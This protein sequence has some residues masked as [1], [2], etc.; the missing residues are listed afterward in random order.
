M[1]R[2]LV[3]GG[4]VLALAAGV[5]AIINF[6][7]GTGDG[8]TAH[9]P[10][11]EEQLVRMTPDTGEE[12]RRYLKIDGKERKLEVYFTDG[13]IGIR[14]KD[15]AGRITTLKEL[16]KDGTSLTYELSD[17]SELRKIN[18]FRKN[19]T[20][21]STEELTDKGGTMAV[22]YQEDGVTLKAKLEV[23]DSRTIFTVYDGEGHRLFEEIQETRMVT[24]N[25][26]DPYGYYGYGYGQSMETILTYLIYDGAASPLYRQ[27]YKQD[28][29]PYRYSYG[30]Y[31]YPYGGGGQEWKLESVEEFEEGSQQVS[32]KICPDKALPLHVFLEK[33]VTEVTVFTNGIE[34]MVRYLDEQFRIVRLEDKTKS[35]SVITDVPEADAVVEEIDPARLK[36]PMT[37]KEKKLKEQVQAGPADAHVQRML[38][39]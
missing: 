18:V 11:V 4:I 22:L 8:G 32:R 16:K 31:G 37:D 9:K 35:P 14:E 26:Y 7:P 25:S 23:A 20:L 30:P 19:G 1:R 29:N 21:H 5:Y 28:Y 36:S 39:P 6:A 24:N 10:G 3:I 17:K 27:T 13:C 2:I 34:T 12:T 33:K 38:V 15:E